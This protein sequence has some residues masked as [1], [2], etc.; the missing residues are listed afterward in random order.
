MLEVSMFDAFVMAGFAKAQ[1]S[2]TDLG[3]GD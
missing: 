1:L 2:F 3:N